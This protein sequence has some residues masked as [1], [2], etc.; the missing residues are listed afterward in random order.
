MS[1]FGAGC[2]GE[3]VARSRIVPS[4]SAVAAA[5]EEE[6]ALRAR[7]PSVASH[8]LPARLTYHRA[9]SSPVDANFKAGWFRLAFAPDPAGKPTNR[10]PA[11]GMATRAVST[12]WALGNVRWNEAVA[13][14]GEV[15][16]DGGVG[17]KILGCLVTV[18]GLGFLRV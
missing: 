12:A 5:A 15:A 17:V 8:S 9:A 4:S 14:S 6:E 7:F 13:R 3:V 1:R 10:A 18:Q 2:E 16:C 11:R